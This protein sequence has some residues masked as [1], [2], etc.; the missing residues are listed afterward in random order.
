MQIPVIKNELAG[1]LSALGK[2]VSRTSLIKAYQGIEIEGKA[3]MLYFRTRNV[4]EQIEFRL[5][6]DLEEDFPATLVEYEQFRLAVR[7]CKNKT[8]KLEIDNGEV[9]IEGV[10]LAP[11][12]G[13]FPVPEIIPDQDVCVTELPADTLSALEKL[14]P[15]ADKGKDV[16]KVL[17]GINI[18]GDGFTAANG[19]ELSN[20]PFPLEKTGSVTIPFPLALLATKAFGEAGRLTTWQKDEDTHFE[21]TL[22]AW[23]WRAKAFKEHYP[24]WKRVVP[25][26]TEKTHH[27][28]FQQDRAEMFRRY[29]RGVPDDPRKPT[30]IKL[31]R[32][33]EVPDNLH[34]ESSNGML[35]SILAEFD[36]NWGDLSFVVRK[37][38]LAHLLN[39]GHSRIEINDVLSPFVGTGGMGQF[40]A[41]PVY[42]KKPQAQTE[43]SAEP[44][45][46]QAAPVEAQPIPES[47]ES[48]PVQI[49]PH[50]QENK[51]QTANT[52]TTSI[53]ENPTMNEPIITRTVSAP[54][55][56]F[57]PNTEPVKVLPS[58]D[59]LISGIEA[60]KS[61]LKTLSEESAVMS[62]RIREYALAQ[63]QKDREYQQTKRTLDRVR[64]ATGAA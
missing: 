1:A 53:K 60:F 32:L 16:R 27:V 58:I 41:M 61:T 33:A 12:E 2:L 13:H 30:T 22:G 40:V 14:A 52:N 59:E 56:T 26:R 9:F 49:P 23:T 5:F 38:I 42:V 44:V 20:I 63:R 54:T 29:L 43:Q 10:K 36:P 35:F 39:E 55:Q 46:V 37:E 18:S 6:A 64:V 28:S 45:A 21:L 34:L 15:I 17:S 62:R 25:E 19:K 8:L 31:S 57:A 48:V 47:T 24:N 4:I 51:N 50:P 7:N 11:V 3:N